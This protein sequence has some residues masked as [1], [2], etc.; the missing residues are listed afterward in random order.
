MH[1]D[2]ELPRDLQRAVELL[3]ETPD[4]RSEWIE[5]VI[6]SAAADRSATTRPALPS[7]R[8]SID[9]WMAVAAGIACIAIGAA[10]MYVALERRPI[11]APAATV[12]RAPTAPVQFRLVAPG[13]ASV[14]LVGDFNAWNPVALPMRRSK[15]GSTW[16]VEVGLP[17]GRYTYAFVVDGR[18]A[19]DPSAAQS[20]DDDF[21]V[22]S[23]VLLVRNGKT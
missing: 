7:R 23:S 6:A 14:Q 2:D 17:P 11:A 8:W 1:R 4:V 16:E 12:G 3:R 5:S 19:R 13:A 9:P 10:G 15:D 20:A 21:G 22:P 18:L